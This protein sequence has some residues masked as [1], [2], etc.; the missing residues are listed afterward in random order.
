MRRQVI[1]NQPI[2]FCILALSIL[3]LLT[4]LFARAQAGNLDAVANLQCAQEV[5]RRNASNPRIPP[6]PNPPF[7]CKGPH[8]TGT[9]IGSVCKSTAFL[10]GAG[11]SG[12]ASGLDQ[13]MKVLGDLFGKLM[14]GD[15]P[16]SSPPST[17][18]TMPGGTGTVRAIH[19]AADIY[20]YHDGY[21]LMLAA[22]RDARPVYEQSEQLSRRPYGRLWSG[23]SSR[24]RREGCERMCAEGYL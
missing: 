14:G 18:P 21:G 9:C 15:S 7:P 4:P 10:E 24:F 11:Q 23:E 5:A 22:Q 17:P 2:Q 1:L 3:F 13:V 6:P 12:G 8:T 20:G 19:P 16:P